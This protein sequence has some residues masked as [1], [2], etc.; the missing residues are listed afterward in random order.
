M[1]GPAIS[2]TLVV[3]ESISILCLIFLNVHRTDRR[4]PPWP[5]RIG[6]IGMAIGLGVHVIGQIELLSNYRPPRT[7]S[8]LI[9]QF[10]VNWTIWAVYLR[11][12]IPR[13]RGQSEFQR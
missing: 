8:W 13:W 6:Y 7:W 12:A 2:L 5:L 10:S 3:V 1:T 9:F 11:D 4:A